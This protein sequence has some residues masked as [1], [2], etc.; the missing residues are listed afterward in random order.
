MAMIV[1]YF[2]YDVIFCTIC[3]KK[4]ALMFQTYYHHFAGITCFT[5][6]CW[7]ND[8]IG[9]MGHLLII[10]ET[11]TSFVNM[12]VLM[13]LLGMQDSIL[14]IANGFTMTFMFFLVRVVNLSFI[15]FVKIGYV[16]VVGMVT[17]DFWNN[18]PK[19]KLTYGKL[20]IINIFLASFLNFFWFYKMFKGLLKA[21]SKSGKKVQS[22]QN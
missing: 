9:S 16:P 8:Y 3:F 15:L 7:L 5:Q 10:T 12:R 18:Y 11:S 21:I 14:Y 6:A 4:D 20:A 17:G 2:I 1:G 13:S 22:K 19:D